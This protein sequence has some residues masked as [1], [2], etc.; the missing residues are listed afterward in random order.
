MDSLGTTGYPYA[1]TRQILDLNFTL[2]TE[3]NLNEL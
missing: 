1:K 3:V 2:Y